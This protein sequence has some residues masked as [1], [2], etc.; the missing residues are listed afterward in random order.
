MRSPNQLEIA[1]Y[2]CWVSAVIGT[3]VAAVSSRIVFA[4]VPISLSLLLNLIN[5]RRLEVMLNRQAM[6]A[7]MQLQD[8]VSQ[9]FDVLY[10]YQSE[11]RMASQASRPP[12]PQPLDLSVSSAAVSGESQWQGLAQQLQQLQGQYDELHRTLADTIDYLNHSPVPQRLDGLEHRL[13]RVS[14]EL[15]QLRQQWQTTIPIEVP[16]QVRDTS[17]QEEAGSSEVAPETTVD[18]S[19]ETPKSGGSSLNLPFPT[20]REMPTAASSAPVTPTPVPTFSIE[21]RSGKRDGSVAPS[22]PLEKGVTPPPTTPVSHPVRETSPTISPKINRPE[23]AAETSPEEALPGP[24][25]MEVGLPEFQPATEGQP[26]PQQ[27][28][29]CVFILEDCQDWISDLVITPD[30]NLLIAA[31]FDKTIP[32]WHLKTGE[33]IGALTDHESPVCSLTLSQDGSLLASGSWDKTV[34][35]WDVQGV[36]QFRPTAK[37][38]WDGSLFLGDT[39]TDETQ[40]AGSVR[41]LSM[42]PDGRFIVSSWFEAYLQV[43]QV[44]VSPK[45]RR[46]TTTLCDRALVDQGRVE[47][48]CFTPDGTGLVSAGA[49]GSIVVWSFDGETGRFTRD[50]LLTE[51]SVPV[52]AIAFAAG[53]TRLV[54]GSRDHMLRVWDF[55]S[56]ELLG[57]FEGHRGSV[58]TLTVC[59]DG[60]TVVSGSS[61][62]TVKLWSLAQQGEIASFCDGGDA[63]MAVAVSPDGGAIVSGTADGTVKVWRRG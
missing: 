49:D 44:R 6:T 1:E 8:Q 38:P 56:G 22:L 18:V 25:V 29:D 5:R 7:V 53:G 27:V 52:N 16:I 12:S 26:L 28:W 57:L 36:R 40:E 24:R 3:L 58:T 63:V 15:S 54:S 19:Q 62:G 4:G 51:M 37:K 45:R 14:Q 11:S 41:S 43:W 9:E 46:M 2:L 55:A 61:D 35:L 17:V 48:V 30:G 13:T 31:S 33:L 10:R 20:P 34:K 23:P 42:S 59:P 32:V 47:A 21:G 39:L 60:D 50:R